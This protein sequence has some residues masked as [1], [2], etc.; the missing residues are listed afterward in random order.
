MKVKYLPCAELTKLL[1]SESLRENFL[2]DDLFVEDEV[3]LY[4]IPD[5]ER[6]I[7]GS[8]CPKS[9]ILKLEA[10]DEL[11]AEYFCER[12]EM[13]VQNM[14]GT[15]FVN[16]D[17]QKYELKHLELLYIGKG[18]KE[19]SFESADAQNS[20]E[21][22]LL[23]YPAHATYPTVKSAKGDANMINMGSAA[24]AN[25]RVINQCV[26]EAKIQSCQLV[27]GYTRLAE[28]SVW[29]TMPTHTHE[30]RSE[31][32]LYF[33]VENGQCVF[34]LMGKPDETRHLV[35]RNRNVV[36]S[37][38]WSIHSGCGTKNYSFVWGM[39]GE[40]KRFDDMDPAPISKL[41]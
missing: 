10:A 32:Y 6:A 29:N 15:G 38:S 41:R 24:E 27:T 33:D 17:G 11:R 9:K 31:I 20:A 3:A 40:N 14:G 30:R 35:V 5:C 22:Y 12:R 25:V 16:V 39:G 18:A 7:V 4:Y 19:I 8:A 13:S 23:S 26:C 21:F 37:P 34:H 2:I 28:G 36:L 1:D